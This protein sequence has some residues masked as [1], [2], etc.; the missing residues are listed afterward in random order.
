MPAK[1]PPEAA[2]NQNDD[3]HGSTNQATPVGLLLR[4]LIR[5]RRS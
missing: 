4:H 3:G 1:V 2:T 5:Y